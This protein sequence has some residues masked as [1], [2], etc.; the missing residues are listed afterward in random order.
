M[1]PV[2]LRTPRMLLRP[3][4]ASDLE[5][6]ARL[7]ADPDVARYAPHP[8]VRAESDALAHAL[9]E[10]FRRNGWGFWAAELPGTDPFSG[11][12]GIR[13]ADFEAP[14]TPCVE[15]GWRLARAHWGQGLAPEGAAAALG[16]AFED[17]ALDEV[18][19]FTSHANRPSMRVMEKLGM[20][21]D[22]QGDFEH[23]AFPP[24][25]P[26]RPHVL[27]RIQRKAFHKSAQAFAALRHASGS[28]GTHGQAEP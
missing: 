12:I 16:F 1:E 6:F 28:E 19:A 14:F 2:T 10:D 24:G 22:P 11:F 9:M 27:Y 26:L 5:P 13:P 25:H 18:V 8:P 15:M 7:N 21:R 20:I 3:W 17:L 4:R 23:P